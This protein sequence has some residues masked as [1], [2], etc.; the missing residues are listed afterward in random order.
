MQALKLNAA[1]GWRWVV[2]GWRLFRRQPF[3]FAAMLFFYWLLLLA[4][5]AIIG[6]IAQGAGAVLPFVSADLVAAFGSLLVAMLTPALTVGFLQACRLADSGL[7][8]HPVLLLAP[9]RSGRTTLLRLLALGSIQTV[10]LVLILLFTSGADAFRI[11]PNRSTVATSSASTSPVV[12]PPSGR[13]DAGQAPVPPTGDKADDP[14]GMP[15]EA[16]QEAMRR[17]AVERLVQGLAYLPVALLMWY[18]PLLVAWH[19]LPPGKALFFSLVAVWRNRNAFIVYGIAWL[20]VWLTLS[21]AI[22][23]VTSLVGIGNFAAII[24][25]PLVMLLLTCMYCSVYPTYATVFVD[26]QAALPAEGTPPST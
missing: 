8:A 24:A 9:F 18:A 2:A 7:P 17:E 25:A 3:G 26:P 21:I 23:I 15:T 22:A 6:W 12:P 5:S 19:G 20:A 16:E 10:A 4:A 14:P 13:V 1:F 11:D